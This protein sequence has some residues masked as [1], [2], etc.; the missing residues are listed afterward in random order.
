MGELWCLKAAVYVSKGILYEGKSV[1]VMYFVEN[2]ME[3][4]WLRL[5]IYVKWTSHNTNK[6]SVQFS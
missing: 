5:Q 4:I 3:M 6:Y 2:D 1:G